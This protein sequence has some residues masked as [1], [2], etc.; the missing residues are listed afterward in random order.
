MAR[1][2]K[3]TSLQPL[4]EIIGERAQHYSGLSVETLSLVYNSQN[5]NLIDDYEKFISRVNDAAKE[6]KLEAFLNK[7]S[8]KPTKSAKPTATE[9]KGRGGRKPNLTP[10]LYSEA[11]KNG[12]KREEL[13]KNYSFKP[14]QL[15]GFSRKYGPLKK[16]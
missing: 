12:W 5:L 7:E 8:K 13:D 14:K 1:G 6:G 3:E 4:S 15:G 9:D 10:E 2:K 16:D 11:V